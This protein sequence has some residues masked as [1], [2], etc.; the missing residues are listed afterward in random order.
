VIA[1]Y[2]VTAESIL[3]LHINHAFSIIS[4]EIY[5]NFTTVNLLHTSSVTFT[6]SYLLFTAGERTLNLLLLGETGTGKSTWINAFGNYVKFDTLKDAE[7]A[8]G[9]FP[10]R[11]VF[12]VNDPETYEERIIATDKTVLSGDEAA[13]QSVTQEP[14][15]YSF[16]HRAVTVNVI[17]TPGLSSTEDASTDTHDMDKQHVDNILHF[18]GRFDELHAICILLKP[19]Q[20]RITK[21]FAYCIT[22]IL[23]NL[24]ASACNNVIFIITNAKSTNFMPGNTR[25]TLK[26]FLQQ[27]SLERIELTPD[28][29]YCI[30][31]DTVQ[32]VAEHTNGCPHDEG[33]EMIATKS[34]EESVKTTT[35]M[36]TYIQRLQPH[37]V[38]GTQCIYTTRRLIG[39]LSKVLLKTITCSID[40]LEILENKKEEIQKRQ[41]KI[42]S[43][44]KDYVT[45][46][47]HDTLYTEIQKVK[48]KRLDHSNTICTSPE[49]SEVVGNERHFK[50]ICCNDCKGFIS[51]WTCMAFKGVSGAKCKYC[52]CERAKHAWRATTTELKT[53]VL[54]DSTAA[55]IGKILNRDDALRVL[56]EH[57][58]RIEQKIDQIAYERERMLETGAILSLFLEQNV[59]LRAS[60]SDNL[61]SCL[62]NERD[63][64]EIAVSN[65]LR[66]TMKTVG[67]EIEK[68]LD[69]INKYIA[70][71]TLCKENL[72]KLVHDYDEYYKKASSSLKVYTTLEA[73]KMIDELYKLPVDGDTLKV[74][75]LE[76]DRCEKLA[77]E[78][79][80]S[81]TSFVINKISKV[82]QAIKSKRRAVISQLT[83][84]MR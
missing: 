18:I 30:E 40:N 58:E 60:T 11:T 45:E 73:H 56:N 1:I 82:W 4:T 28:T 53:Q 23:R 29:M 69:V 27:N 63:A 50:Q 84:L 38:N 8:G 67:N 34:W 65:S 70:K 51:T 42:R 7:D 71:T 20:T 24:H 79:D 61:G 47:L 10:I 15:T 77:I 78:D 26:N 36:L 21:A 32:H 74:A 64:Y 46:D 25:S 9:W 22:E 31:N 3:R 16:K 55:G 75:V 57:R 39:I 80:Q 33:A 81:K 2:V 41:W 68:S 19:N 14:R 83:E 37:D 12:N 35:R 13:G 52:G 54:F 49:C 6:L 44:P 59:L 43:S 72:Q 17:D 48:V 76:V 5:V 66:D 62:R